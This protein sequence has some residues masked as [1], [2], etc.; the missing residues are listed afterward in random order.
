M[1]CAS[2]SFLKRRSF[3]RCH[4]PISSKLLFAISGK[5]FLLAAWGFKN[6]F[7]GKIKYLI[8][9][10]VSSRERIVDNNNYYYYSFRETFVTSSFDVSRHLQ[11]RPNDVFHVKNI[12][13]IYEIKSLK[14]RKSFKIFELAFR[15]FILSFCSRRRVCHQHQQE[16]FG[17]GGRREGRG[18]VSPSFRLSHANVWSNARRTIL[19]SVTRC[20]N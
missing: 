18:W 17:R 19:P 3:V 15:S 11:Q 9:L 10:N 5:S 4:K 20:W 6:V 8:I 12:Y 14:R 16:K 13:E 7:F 2:T 1:K